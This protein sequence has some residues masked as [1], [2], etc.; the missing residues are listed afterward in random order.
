MEVLYNVMGLN[1]NVIVSHM[2]P[3]KHESEVC[4]IETRKVH[5]VPNGQITDAIKHDRVL[6]VSQEVYDKIKLI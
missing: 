1:F 2:L 3:H 6:Y 5:V 4:D